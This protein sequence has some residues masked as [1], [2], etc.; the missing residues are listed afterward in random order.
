MFWVALALPIL[1]LMQ[2]WIHTHLHGLSLLLTGKPDRATIVYAVILFPGVLLHELSHWITATLLGVRTGNFSIIPRT[3][4]DGTV[5]LGYV[6]YY[7]GRTLGPIRESLIG[8][9]PLLIGTAV[10]LFMGFRIFN[11]GNL[12]S[13]IQAGDVGL[14]TLALS[15]VYNT[16]DFLVWLYLLFTIC[17]A[18]MPSRSDRRAWPAFVML[19][20]AMALVLYLLG[21]RGDLFA[22]LSNL[23]TKVFGFLGLAFSMSIAVDIMFM[24][25]IAA[26][27]GLIGRI[28]GVN[29]V[30]GKSDVAPGNHKIVT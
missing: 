6:E 2:R 8:G 30:Y 3:Q 18:M 16:K 23:A 26:L 22:G 11:V 27:E 17:N 5:Q 15:D 19:M 28:T 24:G 20:S 10:I 29:V 13:A 1:L 21:V 7:K 9:A 12:V 25:F 14:L 4:S